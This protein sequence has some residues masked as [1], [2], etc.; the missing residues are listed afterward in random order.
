MTPAQQNAAVARQYL[1]RASRR[2]PSYADLLAEDVIWWTP[3]GSNHGGGAR[4][5]KAAVMEFARR[6][7][8]KY[9]ASTP[10]EMLI[11]RVV[12]DDHWACAQIVLRTQTARGDPYTNDIHI[13][14]RIREGRIVLAR[15]YSD[16][17][18]AARV[19]SAEELG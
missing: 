18:Q 13:A 4:I 16:T 3:P 14:F 1:E 15:E 5:G 12:A 7:S 19:F 6:G 2:D 10:L 17:G 8:V 9:S 11:E